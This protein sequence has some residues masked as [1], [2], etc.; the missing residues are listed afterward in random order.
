MI[1]A[2]ASIT[3][4]ATRA[5]PEA[6]A[7][8]AGLAPVQLC[9]VRHVMVAQHS[10]F[11]PQPEAR[12]SAWV[13]MPPCAAKSSAVMIARQ[14]A[15]CDASLAAGMAAVAAPVSKRPK[16]T[17]EVPLSVKLR[18]TY[19]VEE[20]NKLSLQELVA[21]VCASPC[22]ANPD[23]GWQEA[24]PSPH[25]GRGGG[26]GKTDADRKAYWIKWLTNP[27]FMTYRETRVSAK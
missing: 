17:V 8:G 21:Q 25:R 18:G 22:P 5:A 11:A 12:T 1:A 15:S 6:S 20:V 4:G 2:K 16:K 14:S 9:A 10:A 24:G 23:Y 26:Q 13:G 3:A 7:A 27:E 19:T